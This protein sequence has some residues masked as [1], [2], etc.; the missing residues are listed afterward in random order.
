[1]NSEGIGLGLTISQK[2]VQLNDGEIR[3]SS[4]GVDRGAQFCFKMKMTQLES[5]EVSELS[6]RDKRVKKLL[7]N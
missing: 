6:K 5:E 7:K 3:A 1:M 4:D 2:L